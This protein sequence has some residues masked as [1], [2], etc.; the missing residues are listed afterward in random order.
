MY[1]IFILPLIVLLSFSSS[2]A[3]PKKL[4]IALLAPLSGPVAFLGEQVRKGCVLAVEQLPAPIKER[5]QFTVQDDQFDTKQSLSA[6]HQLDSTGGV[7]VLLVTGSPPANALGPIIE[8]KDQLLVA[9]A[10]SDPEIVKGRK[11]SFIH[12]VIPS[13]LAAPLAEEIL[14]RDLKRIAV[15]AAEVSGTLADADALKD[16]LT[17][18]GEGNRIVYSASFGREV[19]DFKSSISAMKSK[20]V[21]AVVAVLFPPAV[22][23]FARQL[24][25]LHPKAE[26]IGMETIEEESE[27]KAAGGALEG[28]W[29]VTAAAP[30][31][32]FI[33]AYRARF[34]EAPGMAS[35]NGYDTIQMIVA[36]ISDQHA[37]VSE[38]AEHLRSVKGFQG[39]SGVYSAS[40]DNRFTLPAALRIVEN[41]EFKSL[42]RR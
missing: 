21:D 38:V 34:G 16:E 33:E 13:Q 9:V 20:Q 28:A 26:L 37:G 31:G 4:R 8:K 2:Y 32:A 11:K 41:G 42:S 7:D 18:R 19:V 5:V 25:N 29:Y 23:T 36:G 30:S 1:R 17:R 35:G 24:R 3:E 10:A 40:G 27:V 6:Y 12:W 14:R 15:I 39:A 22:S